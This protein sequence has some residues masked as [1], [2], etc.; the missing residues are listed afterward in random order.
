MLETGGLLRMVLMIVHKS[1]W[2]NPR[3]SSGREELEKE[4]L[5]VRRDTWEPTGM[6]LVLYGAAE[7]QFARISRV[8]RRAHLRHFSTVPR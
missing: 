7:R 2:R 3:R 4:I 5:R 6:V 1:N 8:L